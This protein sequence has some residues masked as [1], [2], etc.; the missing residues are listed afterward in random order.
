MAERRLAVEIIAGD[1]ATW[2][3]YCRIKADVVVCV[4]AVHHLGPHAD[5]VATSLRAMANFL[6]P[7]GGGGAFVAL[8]TD[9][10]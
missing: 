4:N 6:V 7:P 5:R 8:L 3:T 9:I 1:F 2:L 10:R